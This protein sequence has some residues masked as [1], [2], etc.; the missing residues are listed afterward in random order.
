MN[1]KLAGLA[2]D[3]MEQLTKPFIPIGVFIGGCSL[4]ACFADK[5]KSAL[6]FDLNLRIDILRKIIKQKDLTSSST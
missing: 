2:Y 3:T 1:P 6:M 4:H 5:G